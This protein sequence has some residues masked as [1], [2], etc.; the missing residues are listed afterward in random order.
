VKAVADLALEVGGAPPQ[1]SW[2]AEQLLL[3]RF[4]RGNAKERQPLA[5]AAAAYRSMIEWRLE[6]GMAQVRAELTP[7]GAERSLWPLTLPRFKPLVE[8]IGTGLAHRLGSDAEGNPSSLVLLHLYD[9]KK[10]LREGLAD[11]LIECQRFIDEYWSIELERAS[12]RSSRL[13]AR[14]DIIF[15][16]LL[17]LFH[18]D[19]ASIRLF[20]RLLAGSKHYPESV[21]RITSAGNFRAIVGMYN[22]LIRPL[23]PTHTAEKL[24]VLGA[25]FK[26]DL[27]DGRSLSRDTSIG[28]GLHL[29]CSEDQQL[30]D[31][32]ARS[33]DACCGSIVVSSRHEAAPALCE[34]N[35]P[36]ETCA[37]TNRKLSN[38]RQLE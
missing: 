33:I 9:L 16:G 15:V 37:E 13:V 12:L 8:C 21:R 5:A 7:E 22:R 31:E 11:K 24:N 1:K 29:T 30:P 35:P 38:R 18:F 2:G 6:H 34:A 27:A 28:P 4:V 10:I 3:L 17:G 36:A 20:P 32:L 23:V 25:V 26:I 14:H 19:I